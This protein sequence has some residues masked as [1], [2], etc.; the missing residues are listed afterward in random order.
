MMKIPQ[1]FGLVL[2]RSALLC[3]VLVLAGCPS[4]A[5]PAGSPG[6]S[7]PG[8]SRWIRVEPRSL[9]EG[10]REQVSGGS[11][12]TLDRSHYDRLAMSVPTLARVVPERLARFPLSS[13][14]REEQEV[15]ATITGTTPEMLMLLENAG[16]A[17]IARGRFLTDKDVKFEEP[18][19]VISQS[20]AETL[21]VG[22]DPLGRRVML[23]GISLRIVGELEASDSSRLPGGTS[24]IYVPLTTLDKIS[25][26]ADGRART[27]SR[28]W[29]EVA[30]WDQVETTLEIV[31]LT[32]RRAESD[33]EIN[34]ERAW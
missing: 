1:P 27:L 20:L 26:P 19:A 7:A 34:V 16:A 9:A 6:P 29:L 25:P 22:A 3:A 32:V 2:S 31:E 30:E 17:R 8:I 4:I 33:A 11:A 14:E 10:G 18:V 28:L 5:P 23:K 12:A 13:D 15:P 24:D 21:F